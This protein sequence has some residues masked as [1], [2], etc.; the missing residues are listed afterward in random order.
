MTWVEAEETEQSVWIQTNET[1]GW[2]RLAIRGTKNFENVKADLKTQMTPCEELG[3]V[4]LH[5]GFL[6]CARACKK[7]VAPHLR[8]G[9]TLKLTG[10]SLGGATA[11]ILSLL[12]AKEGKTVATCVTYGS[13]RVGPAELSEHFPD[14]F[15]MLRVVEVDDVVARLPP[16]NFG[17]KDKPYV[18]HGDCIV[19]DNV[20]TGLD[21]V[22]HA[23]EATVFSKACLQA[24]VLDD[25]D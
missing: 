13:P 14:G 5:T 25:V 23:A 15:E 2:Q 10:H 12:L 1:Q 17:L 22:T 8:E 4:P 7:A 16:V 3:G 24:Y 11:L 9:Y 19:I 18:H 21:E 20:L 6:E